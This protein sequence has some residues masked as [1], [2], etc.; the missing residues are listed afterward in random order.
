M[1]VTAQFS[2][3]PTSSGFLLLFSQPRS[4]DSCTLRYTA[5][6]NGTIDARAFFE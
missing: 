6:A 1:G 3:I 4:D 2:Q 5:V